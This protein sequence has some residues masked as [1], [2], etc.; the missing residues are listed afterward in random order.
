[1]S[2]GIDDRPQFVRRNLENLYQ[3]AQTLGSANP[4]LV[5]FLNGQ[6]LEH[7]S[8]QITLAITVQGL[9]DFIGVQRQRLRHLADAVVIVQIE[10]IAVASRGPNVPGPH[11]RVLQAGQLIRLLSEIVQQTLQ[12]PRRDLP[13]GDLDRPFDHAF[14]LFAAET[15]DQELASIDHLSQALELAALAD[16]VR[17]HRQHDINRHFALSDR[18]KQDADELVGHFTLRL[19]RFMKTEDLLELIDN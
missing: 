4:A 1:M 11:Q 7:A 2:I 16:E 6:C 18:L 19:P 9:V 15:W 10:C 8:A 3:S 17:S 12:Q 5:R 14:V 13:T